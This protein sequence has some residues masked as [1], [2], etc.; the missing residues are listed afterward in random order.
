M[1]INRTAHVF[2]NMRFESIVQDAGLQGGGVA[3]CDGIQAAI[4]V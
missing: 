4:R 2:I 3:P 1:T